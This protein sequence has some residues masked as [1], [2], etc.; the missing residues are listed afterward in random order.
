MMK[1]L[2]RSRSRNANHRHTVSG[3]TRTELARVFMATNPKA[4]TSAVIDYIRENGFKK[5]NHR[6]VVSSARRQTRPTKQ[7]GKSNSSRISLKS[8]AIREFVDKYPNMLPKDMQKE[9]KQRGFKVTTQTISNTKNFYLSQ[10]KKGVIGLPMGG[11]GTSTRK[12]IQASLTIKLS[13]EEI[14]FRED[15]FYLKKFVS[16]TDKF[17]PVLDFQENMRELAPCI[18]KLGGWD[19]FIDKLQFLASLEEVAV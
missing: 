9:L 16:D 17:G 14:T 7:K 13:T 10:K 2:T 18:E 8:A 6:N 3:K 5:G 1:T 15:L 11:N 19:P 12:E 4:E